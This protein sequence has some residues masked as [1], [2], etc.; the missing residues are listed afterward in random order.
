MTAAMQID[1]DAQ[2]YAAGRVFHQWHECVKAHD[3]DALMTLY[4]DDAVFESPLVPA[5]LD[6]HASGVLRGHGEIRSFFAAA[7]R[8]RPVTIVRG[9]RTGRYF[10]DGQTLFWEYPRETPDGDQLELAEVMDID[11]GLI[12]HHRVYWGWIGFRQLFGN[13]LGKPR[14][15]RPPIVEG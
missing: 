8:K 4:A 15:P 3:I 11:G 9:F 14:A 6:G 10:T 5:I 12:R 2:I 7:D 13:L 1:T